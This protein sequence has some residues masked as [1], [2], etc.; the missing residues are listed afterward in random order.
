MNSPSS[1][2][3]PGRPVA[4]GRRR[5]PPLADSILGAIGNTPLVELRQ[6]VCRRGL[7]GRILAKL[8]YLNPGSSKKDRVALEIVR[9]ARDDGRLRP[10]QAVVEVTSGNKY[11]STDHSLFAGRHR[12]RVSVLGNCSSLS[13]RNDAVFGARSNRFEDGVEVNDSVSPER[14]ENSGDSNAPFPK[15]LSAVREDG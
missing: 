3:D 1:I 7:D 9:R 4:R 5:P 15:A 13:E 8:E 12:S 6:I 10:G 14:A 11:L 2:L